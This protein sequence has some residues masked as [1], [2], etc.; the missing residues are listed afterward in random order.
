MMAQ[1]GCDGVVIGRGCLGRPWLFGQLA[2][3]FGGRAVRPNP[4]LGVVAS[5]LSRHG[6]MLAEDHGEDLAVRELRKHVGWYLTGFAVGSQARQALA[7]VA[8][9]AELASRLGDLNPDLVLPESARR[10][11]RGH[12]G[13]PRPVSLPAGWFDD[14]DDP[15]PP[16][17]ADAFASGG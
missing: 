10:L 12:I 15:R 9:L 3:V 17:G 8:S 4:P 2:D 6:S 1:T 16:D 11:P 13:G 14:P 7:Q 5:T